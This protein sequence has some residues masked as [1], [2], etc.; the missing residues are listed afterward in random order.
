MELYSFG[1]NGV[2]PTLPDYLLYLHSLKM[3]KVIWN[4]LPLNLLRIT[5]ICKSIGDVVAVNRGF[6]PE[7]VDRNVVFELHGLGESELQNFLIELAMSYAFY[8]RRDV[9]KR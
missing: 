2:F 7:L 3:T 1:K 6:L 9:S 4:Y 8:A 5:S